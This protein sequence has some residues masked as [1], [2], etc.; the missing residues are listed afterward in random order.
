MQQM[1]VPVLLMHSQ[2]DELVPFEHA[3][4]LERSC[5]AQTSHWW[6][7]TGSHAGFPRW[8]P[9]YQQTIREFLGSIIPAGPSMLFVRAETSG[10]AQ[11]GDGDQEDRA[12][13]G[14]GRKV[15]NPLL[16]EAVKQQHP[17]GEPG[18]GSKSMMDLEDPQEHPFGVCFAECAMQRTDSQG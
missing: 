2:K 5:N 8:N 13:F 14:Q 10:G 16:D 11:A 3:Q 9:I 4:I 1:N 17:G 18:I 7:H 12:L 6:S 15:A